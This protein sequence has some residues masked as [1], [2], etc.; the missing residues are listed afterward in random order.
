MG[1]NIADT[2]ALPT[3]RTTTAA[4]MA[5]YDALPPAFRRLFQFAT[6][7]LS[8][9]GTKAAALQAGAPPTAGN[10]VIWER[11]FRRGEEKAARE[12]DRPMPA[13]RDGPWKGNG[14]CSR[15]RNGRSRRRR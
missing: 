12:I 3:L 4:E 15:T 2:E 14:S 1:A 11:Q 7:N 5:A 6:I 13:T 9:I 10:L 8:A